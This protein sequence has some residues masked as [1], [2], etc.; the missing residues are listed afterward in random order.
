[1]RETAEKCRCALSLAA[2]RPRMWPAIVGIFM[3][4]IFPAGLV[5]TALSRGRG[6][7]PLELLNGGARLA[8]MA[9]WVA[10]LAWFLVVLPW[11]Q[12]ASYYLRWGYVAAAVIGGGIAAGWDAAAVVAATAL[13]AI[14]GLGAYLNSGP[15]PAAMGIQPPLASGWYF[16][17]QGGNSG[18]L[19]RHYPSASQRYALDILRLNRWGYRARGLFPAALERY[20]IY[21][22]AVVCPR[23]G[24]V[25]AVV[26]GLPDMEPITQQD[27]DHV[28][29]NHVIICCQPDTYIGLAHLQPGSILVQP[30]AR[31]AA[32]QPIARVGNSGN[33]TEPHLHLHAKRGGQ[34]DSMLD[35]EGIPMTI[36]G[37]F[38]AR[39]SI[40]R[41]A[42]L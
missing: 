25:T 29:G 19:N 21:G 7:S 8:W 40:F 15:R 23:D 9:G 1:M 33:S 6:L 11:A 27:A 12:V 41:G 28:A 16:V 34:P 4:W 18:A 35:G 13:A 17:G 30:G 24:I 14:W 20:C 26:D 42:R 31:V 37:R 5:W 22:A 2:R 38:L 32:G 39:N 36:G 10:C 3:Q